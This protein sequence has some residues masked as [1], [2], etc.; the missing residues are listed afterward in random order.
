MVNPRGLD[1]KILLIF[2]IFDLFNLIGLFSPTLVTSGKFIRPIREC[3]RNFHGQ[4]GQAYLHPHLSC[5][6]LAQ[7]VVKFSG[8]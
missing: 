2:R 7:F 4:Q 3:V 8:Y 6:Y 1:C 5:Q